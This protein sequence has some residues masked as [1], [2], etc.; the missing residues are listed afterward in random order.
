MAELDIVLNHLSVSYPQRF[1]VLVKREAAK[2]PSGCSDPGPRIN[3][4]VTSLS[5][6]SG[7]NGDALYKRYQVSIWYSA[8]SLT[9]TLARENDLNY[10]ELCHP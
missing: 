4:L 1:E 8:K 3:D 2:L 6:I 7:A 9:L 5:T 10:Y